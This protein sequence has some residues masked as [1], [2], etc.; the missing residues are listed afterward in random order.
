MQDQ[1]VWASSESKLFMQ[2]WERT[3]QKFHLSQMKRITG[4]QIWG[5][6]KSENFLG[7]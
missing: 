1:V 7:R 6:R 5:T 2:P 3:G 4:K